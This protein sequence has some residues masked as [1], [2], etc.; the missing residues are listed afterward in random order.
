MLK[1]GKPIY[2][3]VY[4]HGEVLNALARATAHGGV[5]LRSCGAAGGVVPEAGD[6]RVVRAGAGGSKAVHVLA[7]LGISPS[8]MTA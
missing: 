7:Q 3:C 5:V 8:T 6:Y 1:H 2:S 4:R